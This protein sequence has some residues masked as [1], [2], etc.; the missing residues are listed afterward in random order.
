MLIVGGSAALLAIAIYLAWIGV[1]S[2]RASRRARQAERKKASREPE[3]RQEARA[4]IHS[5]S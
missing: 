2:L 5:G 4:D 3:R 1:K